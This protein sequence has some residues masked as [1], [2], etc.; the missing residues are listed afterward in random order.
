MEATTTIPPQK[1]RIDELNELIEECILTHNKKVI[2]N[3]IFNLENDYDILAKAATNNQY[4]EGWS[5]Q[6]VLNYIYNH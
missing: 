1:T 6:D 4:R 2:V 5:R 3:M